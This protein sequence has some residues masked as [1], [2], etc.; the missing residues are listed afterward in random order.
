LVLPSHCLCGCLL[1][2]FALGTMVKVG[3]DHTDNDGLDMDA[4]A[5]S[6]AAVTSNGAAAAAAAAV[7]AGH[8]GYSSAGQGWVAR[9]FKQQR[10]VTRYN[11]AD[12]LDRTNVGSFFGAVQV[13]VVS[14]CVSG[15]VSRDV[16]GFCAA[17]PLTLEVDCVQAAAR[18]V[19]GCGCMAAGAPACE[20][21]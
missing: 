8:Q 1:Q 13:S 5:S 2:S 3:P 4:A 15:F 18:A 20:H 19:C 17:D 16:E 21:P 7:A 14:E 12:S 9:W 10:G 6:T 11:C